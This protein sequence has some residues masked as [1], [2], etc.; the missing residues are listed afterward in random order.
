MFSTFAE[1]AVILAAATV[2][3]L[4]AL[5]F[6]TRGRSLEVTRV[7]GPYWDIRNQNKS[8]TVIISKFSNQ[9]K[10]PV[11]WSYS[12]KLFFDTDPGDFE[13][14][15]IVLGPGERVTVA[16][17]STAALNLKAV[18]LKSVMRKFDLVAKSSN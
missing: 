2:A 16:L 9:T 11:E 6:V 8:G 15:D 14:A 3:L 12:A 17:F 4:L 1:F 18:P 13:E 7:Q 5:M 10:Y